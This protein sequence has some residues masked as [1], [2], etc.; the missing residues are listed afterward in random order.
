V[1]SVPDS[2]MRAEGRKTGWGAMNR[3]IVNKVFGRDAPITHPHFHGEATIREVAIEAKLGG[4]ASIA[5]NSAV[6]HPFIFGIRGKYVRS[7]NK[8][9]R[10]VLKIWGSSSTPGP[11]PIRARGSRSPQQERYV[12]PTSVTF[13]GLLQVLEIN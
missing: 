7:E 5:I 10:T 1:K 13:G 9:S 12:D 3:I 6:V 11:N 8:G 2:G 4:R